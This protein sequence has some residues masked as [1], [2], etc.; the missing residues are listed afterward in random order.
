MSEPTAT[1]CKTYTDAEK[2]ACTKQLDEI[3]CKSTN[4]T[5]NPWFIA[6]IV[7]IIIIILMFIGFVGY[8]AYKNKDKIS[9]YGSRAVGYGNVPQASYGGRC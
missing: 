8:V 4:S 5:C 2:K 9:T 6:G 1:Q 3:K 7:M